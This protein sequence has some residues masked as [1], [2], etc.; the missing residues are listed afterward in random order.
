MFK[1]F[2]LVIVFAFVVS[3][4][5]GIMPADAETKPIVDPKALYG[6]RSFY[7]AVENALLKLGSKYEGAVS[8]ENIGKS[9]QG[10][11][12]K[13]VKV[14]KG[15]R[16]IFINAAHHGGEYMTAI[17]VLNQIEALLDAYANGNSMD[18]YDVRQLLDEVSIYFVPLVNPDGVEIA[19]GTIPVPAAFKGRVA[20]EEWRSNGNGVDLNRNYAVRLDLLGSKSSAAAVELKG[21]KPFS[22]PE[23]AAVKALVSKHAFETVV[24]Y[25]SPGNYIYWFSGQK[26]DELGRDRDIAVE[27]A[28]LSRYGAEEPGS[29]P[30]GNAKDMEAVAVPGG[31]KDWFVQEYK[32]PGFMIEIGD[33]AAVPYKEYADVW[34]ANK[35]IPLYLASFFASEEDISADTEETAASVKTEED[36]IITGKILNQVDNAKKVKL[37]DK[38]AGKTVGSI[39][40]GGTVKLMSLAFDGWYKVLTDDYKVAYIDSRYVYFDSKYSNPMLE[41]GMLKNRNISTDYIVIV[42]QS[43]Q[44]MLVYK[45]DTADSYEQVIN[46]PVSTGAD[47][48]PTPNGW[49]TTKKL[50]G[51]LG[52]ASKYQFYMPYYV[53]LKGGY[54]IHGLPLDKSKQVPQELMDK[55]GEKD[56]HGCV[57]LRTDLAKYIYNNVKENNLVII[58]NDPPTINEVLE[59]IKENS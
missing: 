56:S 17:L 42:N 20:K 13:G 53:Q 35:D 15:S 44:N 18:G 40:V 33:K 57:R 11:D 9:A 21:S 51:A 19:R 23:T 46:S 43:T 10:R 25:H 24:C 29:K 7:E 22:E 8:L 38:P 37:Y 59:L 58:D 55:L 5:L 31:M 1:R 52:Y 12:I 28:R 54:L 36:G 2:A 41:S 3:C 6:S 30:Q 14:G 34:E 45:K 4:F 26:G 27:L 16:E 48:T 49:F 47:S 39:A 50:R 32:K